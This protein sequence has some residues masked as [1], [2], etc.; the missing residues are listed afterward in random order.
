MPI[1]RGLTLRGP[2]RRTITRLV[3]NELSRLVLGG[4]VEPGDRV[5]VEVADGKLG[6]D[7]EK[8]VFERTSEEETVGASVSE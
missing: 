4:D 6:F 2:L 7:V 8:G 5:A 3:E 1:R